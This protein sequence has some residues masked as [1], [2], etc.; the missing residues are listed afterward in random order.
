[1][2]DPAMNSHKE[3]VKSALD[4]RIFELAEETDPNPNQ[5]IKFKSLSKQLAAAETP[6]K[7]QDKIRLNRII[8]EAMYPTAIKMSLQSLHSLIVAQ[9]E[10]LYPQELLERLDETYLKIVDKV[11]LIP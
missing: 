2:F 3:A 4:L 10:Q 7:K 6:T 1:M 5:L 9:I 8:L 11:K